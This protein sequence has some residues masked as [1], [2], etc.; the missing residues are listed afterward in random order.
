MPEVQGS[1]EYC[2]WKDG[3]DEQVLSEVSFSPHEGIEQ[4]LQEN[5]RAPDEEDLDDHLFDLWEEVLILGEGSVESHVPG[6]P[7][8]VPG[9]G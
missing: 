7:E 1:S 6:L 9:T 5:Q 4:A 2:V 8:G 3:I